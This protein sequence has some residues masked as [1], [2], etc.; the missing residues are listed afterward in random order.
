MGEE[1]SYFNENSNLN[2]QNRPNGQNN[3]IS[4]RC[5]YMVKD[6]NEYIQLINYRYQNFTNQ[7]ILDKIKILNVNKKEELI[8]QKKF[9]K[10]GIHT[11]DFIIEEPL[12]NMSFLFSGCTSLTQ[13]EFLSCDTSQVID[14]QFMFQN[15]PELE[16][17]DLSIFNTSNVIQMNSMFSQ[18]LK[19]KAINGIENFDTFNVINMQGMF[20]LCEELEY[21]DL[22][23]FNT[24]NVTNMGGMFD[25]CKN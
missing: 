5:T 17:V 22:S 18:C 6:D 21:L 3:Q 13:V 1:Y 10:N 15:C 16:Y 20:N 25:C 9:D 24:S 4:F 19:L 11:I 23:N 14:M 2:Y 12:N 8:L 7:E